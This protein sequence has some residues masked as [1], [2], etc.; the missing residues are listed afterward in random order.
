MKQYLY[1]Y[2]VTPMV[3]EVGRQTEITVTPMDGRYAFDAARTYTVEARPQTRRERRS[4]YERGDKSAIT[5]LCEAAGQYADAAWVDPRRVYAAAARDGKLVFTAAFDKEESYS[6]WISDGTD[7]RYEPLMVYAVD[8]DLCRL[9]PLKGDFH[10]HSC[11]SD[12]QESPDVVAASYRAAGFDFFA[13]TDHGRYAPSVEMQAAYADVPLGMLLVNGEEVHA[14]ENFVHV[15]HFGG[16]RSVN[17]QFGSDPERFFREVSEIAATEEIPYSDKFL[18]AENRWLARRIREAG[19]LAVYCHPHWVYNGQH[20]DPD[21]LTRA[22]LRAG[23]FDAFELIGGQISHE[24]D[25]QV[26]MWNDLRAEG[27]KIPI[28]GASDSHGTIES[29]LFDQ[30]FTVV[31]AESLSVPAII[32]AVK[33]GRSAAVEYRHKQNPT[34][35]YNTD[36]DEYSVHASYRLVAYTRFLLDQYFPRQAALTAR[37]GALMREYRLGVAGAKESLAALAGRTEAFYRLSFAQ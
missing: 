18:Y 1:H 28:T 31:F 5:A 20:N 32:E 2:L 9:R 26:A 11:R 35:Y 19:G 27:C 34:L 8:S 21:E 7:A 14:P 29:G 3:C 37:E 10:V 36:G 22:V 33:D 13:L 6:L 23:E 24:N 17:D 30:M 15:I 4:V 16:D 25:L 12:G